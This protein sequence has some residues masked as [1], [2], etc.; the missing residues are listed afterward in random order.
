[1]W[2]FARQMKIEKK[3]W[4]AVVSIVAPV[5]DPTVKPWRRTWVPPAPTL[6][7]SGSGCSRPS[8]AGAVIDHA[9]IVDPVIDWMGRL[10]QLTVML[11]VESASVVTPAP[12]VM[13]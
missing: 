8:A 4:L 7:W 6:R 3:M 9:G 12:P 2:P 10:V 5:A 13:V 11:P 1:M